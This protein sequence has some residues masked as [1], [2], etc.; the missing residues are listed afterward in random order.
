MQL[1]ATANTEVIQISVVK[2]FIRCVH[3]D[4]STG[5]GTHDYLMSCP[6]LFR[7]NDEAGSMPIND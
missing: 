6:I 3:L 4:S 1:S 5:V 7:S 2:A